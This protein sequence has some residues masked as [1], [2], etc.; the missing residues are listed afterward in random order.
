MT[1]E[2]MIEYV[3]TN[4]EIDLYDEQTD[5][6]AKLELSAKYIGNDEIITEPEISMNIDSAIKLL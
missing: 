6:G 1:I 4:Y 3:D 5:S 2:M